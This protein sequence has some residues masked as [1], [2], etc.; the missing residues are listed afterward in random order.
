MRVDWVSLIDFRSYTALDWNPEPTVNVLVGENGSGKT[1]LL[2]A[3]AYLGILRS[4]RS[5]TDA[6][7]ITDG[8]EA[9]VLRSQVSSEERTRLVEVE[10]RRHGGR[11]AQVDKS[12]LRRSGDLVGVLRAVWFLPDDLD[13]VKRGP[14]HRRQF[15][16]DLAIQLWPG[17]HLEQMEFSRALRQRN[18]FLRQGDRDDVT[19]DVW[20]RRLAQAGGQVLARRRRVLQ[21]I[22]PELR[23][24]YAELAQAA[25][26]VELRYAPTWSDGPVEVDSE[27]ELA[28]ILIKAL[29]T[30]RFR[31]YE[32]RVTTV[33]PHRDEP[34]FFL[35][36]HDARR[37]ASQGEQ[38]S[39]ALSARLAWHR[40]VRD[41]TGEGPVLLL[42]DVFS[43]LDP[44]RATALAKALPDETQTVITSAR[45]EDVPLNGRLWRVGEGKVVG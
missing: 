35:G 31:D 42:D 19:L 1:N 32:R 34:A 22:A 37:H 30:A 13:L 45:L 27:T 14:A 4:F 43:E 7:M 38:R 28:E 24:A 20:D 18:A 39:I 9:G 36:G 10:L 2:E 11:R 33:G 40:L 16:D 3:I 8:K 23:R 25:E 5:A 15:L 17:A 26:R 29:E 44:G 12:P 21:L 6:E 41:A